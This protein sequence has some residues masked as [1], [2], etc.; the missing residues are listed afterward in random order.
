MGLFKRYYAEFYDSQGGHIKD[1]KIPKHAKEFK[2]KDG[3]YNLKYKEGTYKDKKGLFID[4]RFYKY[5]IE[6]SDPLDLSNIRDNQGSVKVNIHPQDYNTLLE[7]KQLKKLN[8]LDGKSLADYLTPQNLLILG[9]VL[10]GVYLLS[11]GQITP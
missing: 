6:F 4:K 10:V 11:T 2:F 7:S 1:V 5:N 8:E 9:A 3:A